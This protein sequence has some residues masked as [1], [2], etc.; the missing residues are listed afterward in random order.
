MPSR[1]LQL[2][3]LGQSIEDG[4]HVLTEAAEQNVVVVLGKT[5]VG[6]STFIQVALYLTLNL[7]A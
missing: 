3:K 1:Q 6:K 2:E 5:G 7:D 4:E